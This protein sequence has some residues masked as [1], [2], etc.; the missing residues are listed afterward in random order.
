MSDDIQSASVGPE[1][2]LLFT[3]DSLR[4]VPGCPRTFS[5]V[6]SKRFV[7]G[8]YSWLHFDDG[9]LF[10]IFMSQADARSDE[11]EFF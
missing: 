3:T 8:F 4:H 11:S 9:L 7:Q 10:V 1:C 5:P 2:V 6:S